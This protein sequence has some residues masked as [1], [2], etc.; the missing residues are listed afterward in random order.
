MTRDDPPQ[1]P[2]RGV[3]GKRR[4]PPPE[5]VFEI[6]IADGPEGEMLARRQAEVL[7]E[8]TKWQASRQK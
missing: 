1:Q 3:R 4:H 8:I 2:P 6:V 7:W 5:A